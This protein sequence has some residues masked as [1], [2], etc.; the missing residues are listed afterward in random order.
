MLFLCHVSL[1]VPIPPIISLTHQDCLVVFHFTLQPKNMR[2]IHKPRAYITASP[3]KVDLI[4]NEIT[5][6][7]SRAG[8]F[9]AKCASSSHFL[10]LCVHPLFLLPLSN[11]PKSLFTEF[12]I[13]LHPIFFQLLI[14]I[15]IL[16]PPATPVVSLL[17]NIRTHSRARDLVA[18]RSFFVLDVQWLRLLHPVTYMWMCILCLCVSGCEC[19]SVCDCAC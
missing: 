17:H 3:H 8:V 4:F 11:P 19:V 2:S 14:F 6:L 5:N 10:F 18:F 9:R 1:P 7:V 12:H 16:S 13:H 15:F